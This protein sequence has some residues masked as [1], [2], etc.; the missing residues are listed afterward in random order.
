MLHVVKM[1]FAKSLKDVQGHSK[2]H[3]WVRRVCVGLDI[4]RC[5]T[6]TDTP[7]IEYRYDLEIRVGGRSRSMK[8]VPSESLG[9]SRTDTQPATALRHRPR[10]CITSRGKK[11]DLQQMLYE[12]TANVPGQTHFASNLSV[13]WTETGQSIAT[14]MQILPLAQSTN[15]Y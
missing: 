13:H 6:V 7:S 3:R 10:L 8:T 1:Y 4:C 12:T 14:G 11:H 5:C 2:W 15:C 9:T